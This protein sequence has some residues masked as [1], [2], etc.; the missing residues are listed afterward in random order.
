MSPKFNSNIKLIN[1]YLISKTCCKCKNIKNDL[2]TEKIY[3]YSK[4]NL[5]IDRDINAAINIYL[6]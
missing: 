6:L 2:K 4:C 1:E 5:I 3:N